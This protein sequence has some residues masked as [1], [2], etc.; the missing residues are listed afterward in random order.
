MPATVEISHSYAFNVTAAN[1]NSVIAKLTK[2]LPEAKIRF[3]DGKLLVRGHAEDQDFV[4]AALEGRPAK[5]TTVTKGIKVY[6]LPNV[7][8]AVGE[9]I[10]TLGKKLNLDVQFDDAAIQAAGLSLKTEVTVNVKD[11]VEDDLL[12]AVLG[13]AGLTFDRKGQS[14]TVR[15]KK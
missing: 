10:K 3:S 1:A 13:P 15:P 5:Q 12:H 14:I 2:A 9:L 7:K 11:L 4:E 6:S 8:M